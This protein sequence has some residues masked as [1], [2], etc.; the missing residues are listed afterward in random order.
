MKKNFFITGFLA[1][2]FFST[3]LFAQTE[4]GDTEGLGSDGFVTADA[5][6][7]TFKTTDVKFRWLK[8]SSERYAID[9]ADTLWHSVKKIDMAYDNSDMIRDMISQFGGGG[10]S[11]IC[12]KH[13]GFTRWTTMFGGTGIYE[14]EVKGRYWIIFTPTEGPVFVLSCKIGDKEEFSKEIGVLIEA[15]NKVGGY[16]DKNK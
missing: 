6:N 2:V 15:Y 12:V 1:F 7:F 16:A 4:L 5:E 8:D 11:A 13:D 10:I 3:N 9:E 14:S